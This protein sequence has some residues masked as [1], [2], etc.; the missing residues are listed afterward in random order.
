MSV[1]LSV[2]PSSWNNSAPTEWTFMKLDI[3]EFFEILSRKFKCHSN[4]K[5]ITG[6]LHE[7]QYSFFILSRSFLLEW[8]MNQTNVVEKIKT[9]ILCSVKFFFFE[10]L[11]IYE[12]MWNNIVKRGR[13]QVTILRMRIASWILKATNV[14]TGC[15]ILVAFPPQRWLHER[16]SML[17]SCYFLLIFPAVSVLPL[18]T[19]H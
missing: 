18:L 19:D 5:R 7:D 8:E 2:C 6:T 17:L 9:H 10:N 3:W 12:I 11:A 13:P 15:V 1:H 14:H 4:R 16:A